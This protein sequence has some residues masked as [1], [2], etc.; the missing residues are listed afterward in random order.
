MPRRRLAA[1][2]EG[3]FG[4][5]DRRHGLRQVLLPAVPGGDAVE[6]RGIVGE[7]RDAG[8]V[9]AAGVDRERHGAE[10]HPA[11]QRLRRDAIPPRDCRVP[12]GARPPHS[13]RRGGGDWCARNQ[14]VGRSEG[15]SVTG[16]VL[17]LGGVDRAAGR[18][19]GG[20]GCA[21]GAPSV[22]RVHLRRAEGAHACDDDERVAVPGVLRPDCVVEGPSRG[23]R[24]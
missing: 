14:R 3:Q 17:L 9:G 1:H 23:V 15:A 16:A 8:A 19:S 18:P 20:G 11:G 7:E 24:W 21:R 10:Q 22:P 2:Q 6:T 12:D 5:G 13:G 4:G